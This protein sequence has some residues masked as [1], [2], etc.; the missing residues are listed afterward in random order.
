[1]SSKVKI[2]SGKK[3]L[4]EEEG[5]PRGCPQPKM[6]DSSTTMM[7]MEVPKGMVKKKLPWLH[8]QAAPVAT[9]QR[10]VSIIDLVVC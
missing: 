3:N 10:D 1:M 8:C 2:I 5:A 4:T 6:V 7:P 9:S